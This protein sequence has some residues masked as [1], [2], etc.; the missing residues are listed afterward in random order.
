MKG[1]FDIKRLKNKDFLNKIVEKEEIVENIL[2]NCRKIVKTV[3][4]I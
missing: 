3:N 2:R 1:L 4:Q